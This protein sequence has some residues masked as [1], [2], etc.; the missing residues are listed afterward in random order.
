LFVK[1]V[2]NVQGD[3][4]D[5]IVFSTTFGR[6]RH[7][8]FRRNFGVLGQEGGERRLNVAITRARQKVV[9]LT[10]MPISEISGILADGSP[11][12]RPRDY[13]QAYLAYAQA[14]SRGEHARAVALLRQV[15][16]HGMATARAERHRLDDFAAAVGSFIRQQGFT[17]EA[18]DDDGA[19]GIDFAIRHPVTGTF[20]IGIEC[21]AY[22]HPIL[23]TAR[24]REIWR[25]NVMRNAFPIIHRVSARAWYETRSDE[26]QRLSA[27][28][29]QAILKGEADERR[30][31]R[32]NRDA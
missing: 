23:A 14:V 16:P 8:R 9:I 17:P 10:S 24:A 4:R 30:Q 1:N 31:G 12:S 20:G 22:R 19:F 11:P 2:E 13:L 7:R 25:H 6:D 27:G 18:I 26:Q 5:W 21:E 3:E 32:Q 29:A 15:N 28:I